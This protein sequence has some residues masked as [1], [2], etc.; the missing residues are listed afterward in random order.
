[1]KTQKQTKKREE[2]D[3]RPVRCFIC[4]KKMYYYGHPKF[5]PEYEI[6]D[7]KNSKGYVHQK[8]LKRLRRRK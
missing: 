3:I 2:K 4:S 8:C 6:Y 7:S 5:E 1:M